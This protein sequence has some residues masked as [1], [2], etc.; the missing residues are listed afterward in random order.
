MIRDLQDW[1]VTPDG[2]SIFVEYV[3]KDFMAAVA[4]IQGIAKVAEA[5]D[6]HPDI[7]L[8]SYRK[9]RIELSTHSVGQL[10]EKDF[11]LA[12]KIDKLHKSLKLNKIK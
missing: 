5:D 11:L 4:L 3:M 9:L 1:N 6:H 2:K 8:T 10:T 7:H 12:A